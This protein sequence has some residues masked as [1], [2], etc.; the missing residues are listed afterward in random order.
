MQSTRM[1]RVKRQGVTRVTVVVEHANGSNRFQYRRNITRSIKRR[2]YEH[3]L[4]W[5]VIF[6]VVWF[7][8]KRYYDF[9][10]IFGR[11]KLDVRDRFVYT[12]R[13]TPSRTSLTVFDLISNIV[14]AYKCVGFYET[15]RPVWTDSFRSK[16][17]RKNVYYHTFDQITH[18]LNFEITVKVCNKR[19]I[20]KTVFICNQTCL[21][22][23]LVYYQKNNNVLTTSF[24]IKLSYRKC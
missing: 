19:T 22:T 6:V 13:Q 5:W 24:S 3:G 2:T 4:V 15:N 16:C 9:V 10:T 20:I 11:R 14:A 23:C 21:F 18:D 12:R 7:L 17:T 1:T 8:S